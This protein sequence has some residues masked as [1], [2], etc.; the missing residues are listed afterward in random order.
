MLLPL[1]AGRTQGCRARR[2]DGRTAPL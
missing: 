2:G 1:A